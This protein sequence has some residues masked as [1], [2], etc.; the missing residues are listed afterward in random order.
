MSLTFKSLYTHILGGKH[1]IHYWRGYVSVLNNTDRFCSYWHYI[2]EL[3][4]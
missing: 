1:T 4:G 3:N 2:G